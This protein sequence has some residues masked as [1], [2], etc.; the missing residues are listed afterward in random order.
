[1]KGEWHAE[2]KRKHMSDRNPK[3]P[4]NA[5]RSLDDRNHGQRGFSVAS[6]AA[7]FGQGGLQLYGLIVLN[8]EQ[9]PVQRPRPALCEDRQAGALRRR[10]SRHLAGE[11]PQNEHVQPV[12]NPAS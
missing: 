10:R 12:K 11:T 4:A 6:N 2:G 7:A 9:A 1:M 3:R 5:G 8:L